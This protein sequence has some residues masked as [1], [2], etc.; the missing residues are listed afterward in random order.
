[1]FTIA[2][3]DGNS[4]AKAH[5]FT[6]ASSDSASSPDFV[7]SIRLADLISA[8]LPFG[9]LWYAGPNAICNAIEPEGGLLLAN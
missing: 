7:N 4:Y 1:L 9:R 8:A 3:T 6:K 5:S 2:N